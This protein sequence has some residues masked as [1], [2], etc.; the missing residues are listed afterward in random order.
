MRNPPRR[1][2]R[3]PRAWKKAGAVSAKG[4]LA[5]QSIEL[6]C[7]KEAC[8]MDTYEGAFAIHLRHIEHDLD[9][10]VD[11]RGN[12]ISAAIVFLGVGFTGIATAILATL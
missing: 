12:M 3:K 10:R 8:G 9:A 5:K 11:S 4:I 2:A 7:L 1:R 6:S